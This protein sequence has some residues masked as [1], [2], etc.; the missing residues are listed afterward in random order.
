[1][2]PISLSL[3]FKNC[4]IKKKYTAN[5]ET[6]VTGGCVITDFTSHQFGDEMTSKNTE[7]ARII[8]KCD[9]CARKYHNLKNSQREAES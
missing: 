5:D 2:I 4:K 3:T 6:V 1:M 7:N 9:S 8:S